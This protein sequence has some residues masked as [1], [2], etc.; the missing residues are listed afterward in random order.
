LIKIKKIALVFLSGFLMNITYAQDKCAT[1]DLPINKS[2]SIEHFEQWMKQKISIGQRYGIQNNTSRTAQVLRIPVVV[3]IIHNGESIGTG[4]NLS[5]AQIISQIQVLNEDFRRQNA[6]AS[7][8][9]TEFQPFAADVEVEFVLALQDPEGLPTDG[10]VRVK[11]SQSL[12][13]PVDDQVKLSAE[14]YWP[15]EDYFNIWVTDL[16]NPYLGYAQ[17]PVSNLPGLENGNTNR[18]TDG[19]AIDYLAFGSNEKYPDSNLQSNYNLGRTTTHEVGHFLGLRHIWG[20]GDC[21]ADDYC[22][23]TPAA[24]KHNSGYGDTCTFPGP[25]SCG[26]GN[27]DL[28]DMFQNYMDYTDDKCMNLFTLDQKSRIQTVLANSPRRA[29]LTG[30]KGLQEPVLKPLDLEIKDIITPTVS[31]CGEVVRPEIII[32]NYGENSINSVSI[33]LYI[34]NNLQEEKT[35]SNLNLQTYE[36]DTVVFNEHF[37]PISNEVEFTYEISSVNG[38]A[39]DPRGN[40]RTMLVPLLTVRSLPLLESFEAFS[41]EDWQIKNPDNGYTWQIKTAPSDSIDNKAIAT[42]FFDDEKP[43]AQDFLITYPY[44]LPANS[45]AN[46]TFDVAY[47]RYKNETTEGLKI[48]LSTDCG[49]SYEHVIFEKYGKDLETKLPQTSEFTPSGKYHW[50]NELIDLSEFS[51]NDVQISFIAINEFGNN[52]YLDNIRLISENIADVGIKKIVS[53]TPA[54]CE[55]SF[56][57]SIMIENKGTIKIGTIDFEIDLNGEKSEYTHTFADSLNVRDTVTVE[58]P[59]MTIPNRDNKISFEIVSVN[60]SPDHNPLNNQLFRNFLVDDSRE[61]LPLRENFNDFDESSWKILNMDSELTWEVIKSDKSTVA[62]FPSSKYFNQKDE[63]WLLSPIMDFSDVNE[64]ALFFDLSYSGDTPDRL[65]IFYTDD[66]GKTYKPLGYDKEGSEL[67][68]YAADKSFFREYI[69]LKSLTGLQ[70]VR[71]AFVATSGHG[72]NIEVD[73]IE[74]F[75]Q[76]VYKPVIPEDNVVLYP[77]PSDGQVDF[78]FNLDEKEDV[79][80]LLFDRSGKT[81]ASYSLPNTLN[82]THQL[83][84]SEQAKGIYIVKITGQTFQ[85]TQRLVIY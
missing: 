42:S 34:N 27:G 2:E 46:L 4:I 29:T 83:D 48:V 25:N 8:T 79:D 20:D 12:W 84:F 21:T 59:L 33:N 38:G 13:H 11:G 16:E 56:T 68:T 50:R 81:L 7:N 67:S 17:F 70:D 35:I 31:V 36:V 52:L 60:G 37:I 73:N 69:S 63:D 85:T 19:V 32:R 6:D 5:D 10:I 53:P 64:A 14:S 75:L 15:A 45:P 77:N 61:I 3:H 47:A 49:N 57:P 40:V 80:V 76:D 9:P 82:Q 18:N 39:D 66:C 72:S 65:Q 51:G 74:I 30:S 24:S 28:P 26:S 78:S 1:D 43:G 22:N 23:D 62:A 58:I 44:T 54:Q 41:I 71:L 55:G